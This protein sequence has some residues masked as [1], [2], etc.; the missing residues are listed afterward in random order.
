MNQT[1]TLAAALLAVADT[2][3]RVGVSVNLHPSR[4]ADEVRLVD[5]LRGVFGEPERYA[6]DDLRWSEWEAVTVY[7]AT[8]RRVPNHP[9]YEYGPAEE[10]RD[11]R[12]HVA[13][14][15]GD[16][17]VC[18]VDGVDWAEVDRNAAYAL[19]VIIGEEVEA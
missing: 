6:R 7:D 3:D 12:L 2:T 18:E 10:Y 9:G 1:K 19:G 14:Y 16:R 4:P 11:G 13:V 5:A 15:E 8:D 17:H